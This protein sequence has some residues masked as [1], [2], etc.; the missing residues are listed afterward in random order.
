[1]LHRLIEGIPIKDSPMYFHTENYK[2]RAQFYGIK[3]KSEYSGQTRYK[4]L[5]NDKYR[6]VNKYYDYNT[7]GNIYYVIIPGRG[8]HSK[9][10]INRYFVDVSK[11]ALTYAVYYGDYQNN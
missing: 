9:V 6:R 5:V 3:P 7:Q 2:A 11:I 10:V 1:M 4:A 8:S